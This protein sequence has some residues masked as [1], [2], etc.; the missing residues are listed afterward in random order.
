MNETRHIA[1]KSERGNRKE[2][3][4]EALCNGNVHR[5][6]GLIVDKIFRLPEQNGDETALRM[7]RK[8]GQILGL[9]C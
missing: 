9:P 6:R 2:T 3:F 1:Y 4:S 5:L 8:I 7:Y